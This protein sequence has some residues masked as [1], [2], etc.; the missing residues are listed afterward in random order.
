MFNRTGITHLIS[1]SGLHVT[2]FAAIAG[3]LAFALAR[4]SSC[5]TTRLPARKIAAAIGVVAATAYVLLAGA[6]VPA[7]RTLLMLQV[8]ALGLWVA[9][10]GTACV[11]WLWALAAVLVWDPWAGLSP[12]FWLS[13]GAVGLLLYAHAGRIPAPPPPTRIARAASA[14]RA[15]ARTQALVTIGLVP[16]TLAIFQQV[17]LVSPIANAL[18]IPVVTFGVVPL[19]LAGI[20]LPFDVLWKAAH[21]VFAALMIVLDALATS[22]EAVWQQ[23]AP[24]AW[25]IAVAL[26]GVAWLAAP[27]GAPGRCVGLIALLPLFVVVPDVPAPGAFRVTILDVGQGLAVVV[28]TH[29]HTLLYDTGPRYNEESD[30]GGRIVAP[31]LRAAGV[32]RLDAMIVTHQ[33]SDHSGGA[34]SVLATVP[35][36]WLASSLRDD[37]A[38][39]LQRAS[40]GGASYR[41]ESG[42][43]WE[44]DGVRFRVLQP[45]P[46]HYANARLK[47]NDLSCVVRVES[48]FGTALL[49]GDLEARGELELV[50]DDPAFAAGRPAGRSASREHDVVDALVHRRRR[51]RVRRLYARLSQSLRPPAGRGDGALRRVGC[52]HVSHGLRR[53]AD[54]HV[55]SRRRA[56]AHRRARGRPAVLA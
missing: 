51:A 43:H 50:R 37:H 20:V 55:R 9:R 26:A 11:V 7:V 36:G 8:A 28:A 15:A 40:D 49:T 13:F 53:R 39:L 31:Y 29:G 23:H 5:L 14:L 22:P 3:G 32:A 38:I 41:C 46:A 24:P 56:D 27:R 16:G 18:A 10:P 25:A 45:G 2:V 19:A 21:A 17:S 4:R 47:T 42:Q 34:L 33:D 30:A 44:W 35:V 6:Q 54:I 1:I 48:D 12:G 52:P